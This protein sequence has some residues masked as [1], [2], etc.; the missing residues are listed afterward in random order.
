MPHTPP[1]QVGVALAAVAQRRPHIPQLTGFVRRSTSQP[2]LGSASQL[3]KFAAQVR[4]HAPAM[5]DG[6]A[7]APVAH[8]RP[9]PP[10]FATLVRVST[11]HPL[12][13]A[14][15]QLPYPAAQVI[16]HADDAHTAV[17]LTAPGHTLPHAPQCTAEARTSTSQPL[18]ATPSQSP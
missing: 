17:A 8:P 10:Q 16:A 5:H 14:A 12:P 15:S 18:V 6:V 2:L 1:A 7:L 11:S 9:Q 13:A 3:P 4:K